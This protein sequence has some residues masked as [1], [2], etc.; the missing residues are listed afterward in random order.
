MS[1]SFVAK[2]GKGIL[3]NAINRGI[4]LGD[5]G[6][7]LLPTDVTFGDVEVSADETRESQV[8]FTA[9]ARFTE[10]AAVVYFDRI[11]IAQVFA[12]AGITTIEV[13]GALTS[14]ADV[15]AA[16]NTRHS[17]GF[18]EEDIDVTGDFDPEATEVLLTVLP[19]S[20]GYKGELLV[21]I[22]A[23]DNGEGEP[24]DPEL[25]PVIPEYVVEPTVMS[26]SVTAKGQKEDGTMLNG[27]GNPVGEMTVANN[28]EIEL[29]LGARVWKSGD[30]PV[31]QD[32]HYDIV[33]DDEAGDW[34]W[35]FSIAL[36][37]EERPV[38]DLYAVVL[39][40]Q[41]VET[42]ISIPFTLSRDAEGV[43]HFINE[44]FTLDISDSAQSLSGDV[45]QNIQRMTFYKAQL[46]AMTT[47]TFGSPIGD[48]IISLNATRLEGEVPA[49]VCEISA[50]VTVPA[51]Q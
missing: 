3:L 48:F 39:T 49:V 41:S 8:S 30:L 14:I 36:L 40:A 27:T 25:P 4:A 18:S 6:V 29:A 42:G 51:P 2:S 35:P 21:Q 46:G 7:Q 28:G 12:D 5:S 44:E 33:I 20:H 15:A 17:A 1:S 22:V 9:G 38:T 45:V 24:V 34:N 26:G 23:E 10:E 13:G 19:T 31:A 37:Q 11:D 43:Y 32:G 50:N 47:N 16:L